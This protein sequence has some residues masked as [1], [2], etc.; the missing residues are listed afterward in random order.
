M[1]KRRTNRTRVS[2]FYK[3]DYD[4]TMDELELFIED[5]ILA[6]KRTLTGLEAAL[7][8]NRVLASYN[9]SKKRKLIIETKYYRELLSRL[10]E[11]YGH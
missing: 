1:A 11:T 3:K 8:M 7:L 10:V 6:N 9:V 5:F 2:S 4:Y